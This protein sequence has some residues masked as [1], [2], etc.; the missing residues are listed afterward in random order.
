MPHVGTI[1]K[2]TRK[3]FNHPLLI[4]IKKLAPALAAGNSVIVKPS[5]LAPITVLEFAR[6][7]ESAGS[8]THGHFTERRLI[9]VYPV[10]SGVLSVLPG[11]GAMAQHLARNPTVRKVDVTVDFPTL[12]D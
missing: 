2:I 10:P 8:M 7:A 9:Y 3:P 6:M 11:Y 4:S 12:W 1:L 5:E